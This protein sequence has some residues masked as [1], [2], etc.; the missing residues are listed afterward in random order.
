MAEHRLGVP[1]LLLDRRAGEGQ[2]GGL[3]QG[4]PQA[5]GQAQLDL[6]GLGIQPSLEAV[7]GAV[8]LIADHHDVAALAESTDPLLTRLGGELLDGGEHEAAAGAV[9]EQLPQLLAAAGL[10]RR[11]AQQI[12]CSG[13]HAEQLPIEILP[14]GD[15]HQGGISQPWIEQQHP[16]QAGHLDALARPL[17]VPHH[18]ALAVAIR[19]AGL[20]HP[21]HR[22]PYGVELVVGGD[23][24][25]DPAVLLEQA[26]EVEEVEEAARIEHPPDHGL[27]VAVLAERVEIL[28]G[29][30]GAP[31]L[32]PLPVSTERAHTGMHAIA[33]HQQ[34]VGEEQIGDVGFVGLQLVVG[35]PDV[36][37]FFGGVLEFQHRQRQAVDID[38][39]IGPAV[40]PGA[41]NRQLIHHQPVVGGRIIEGDHPQPEAPLLVAVHEGDR[42]ALGEPAVHL[43]V[44][45]QQARQV[46]IAELQHRRVDRGR[47][48]LGIQA[49]QGG[50]QSALEHDLAV[51]GPFGLGSI[52]GQLR[53]EGMA[54][55]NLL[56]PRD[57]LLFQV[58][59]SDRSHPCSEASLRVA[60]A[61]P[62]QP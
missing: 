26:E 36:R 29:G 2:E 3:G 10:F 50:A 41:L 48:H 12:S 30:D 15:D 20:N 24:L 35:G 21:L 40:V 38:D 8:G 55:A 37:F 19:A 58:V 54:V 47:R 17:G 27:Q 42:Q 25:D 14:V 11:F 7:L 13:E 52:G 5:T 49:E 23:L 16:G 1:V 51:V 56:K 44:G 46:G 28:L 53:P 34:H 22:F 59:L 32:E 39:Q 61:D 31:A 6:A 18:T 33:D 4:V 9:L 60:M 43:T 45:R 57:G 62:L